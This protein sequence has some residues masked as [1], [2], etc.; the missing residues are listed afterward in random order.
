MP[1]SKKTTPPLP[2]TLSAVEVSKMLGVSRPTV[3]RLV[4][5]GRLRA[6]KKTPAKNSALLIERTSVE[7]VLKERV[8]VPQK[9]KAAA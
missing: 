4:L 1:S 2:D 3:Q 5:S 9:Q 8:V 7:E 6:I